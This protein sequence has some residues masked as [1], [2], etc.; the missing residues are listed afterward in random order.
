MPPALVFFFNITLAIQGLL[1]FHTNFRIACSSF[2]KNA[3]AILIGIALNVWIAL[4]SIDILTIFIL[5]I[6]EYGMFFHF[7]EIGRASCRERVYV[8]V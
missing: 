4:G 6:H 1:S 2:K 5:P 3:G 8:L 7:F